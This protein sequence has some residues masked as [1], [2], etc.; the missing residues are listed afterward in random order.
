MNTDKKVSSTVR[1]CRDL[2][3]VGGLVS[4]WCCCPSSTALPIPGAMPHVALPAQSPPWQ[5]V[6][7]YSE[8]ESGPC[9][10]AHHSAVVLGDELLVMGGHDQEFRL[11][12]DLWSWDFVHSRWTQLQT[13]VYPPGLGPMPRAGGWSAIHTRLMG[14]GIASCWR[15]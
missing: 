14:D 9:R 3:W 5:G 11:L 10:R 6:W 2:L 8:A 7:K 4:S 13:D 12:D 1:T 15:V